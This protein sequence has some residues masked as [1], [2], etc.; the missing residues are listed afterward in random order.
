MPTLTAS[1]P[2]SIRS[3]PPSAVATLPAI[4]SILC[5]R[6]I[7]WTVSI[8]FFEWPWAVSTDDHVDVRG[9]AAPRSGR[10]GARPPRRR[11][12]AA[13]GR[14][15]T[16]LGNCWSWSMSRI[17]I[18]PVRCELVVDEQEFLDLVLVEDALGLLQRGVRRRRDQV[19]PWSSPR[20]T[21][22]RVRRRELQV[23]VGED[24]A[25]P[26]PRPKSA[27]PALHDRDARDVVLR[28]QLAG[29]S[30]TVSLG[31]QRERVG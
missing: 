4:T 23:A 20:A 6:L 17:V 24:P 15:C 29:A 12:A 14:P 7:R 27:R 18:R 5:S 3:L 28:H 8:T 26:G 2:A 11:T 9:D 16:A 13:R 21:E 25:A 22:G 1:A 31:P 30:P 19:R 10:T